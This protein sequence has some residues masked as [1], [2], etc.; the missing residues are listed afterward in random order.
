MFCI[1]PW[2]CLEYVM[3]WSST[4]AS[5]IDLCFYGLKNVSKITNSVVS[6]K[7][8]YAST[9]IFLRNIKSFLLWY[10]FLVNYVH[11]CHSS[12]YSWSDNKWLAIKW[13]FWFL[14]CCQLMIVGLKQNRDSCG[15]VWSLQLRIVQK[16]RKMLLFILALY[17]SWSEQHSLL[18]L[19]HAH[20]WCFFKKSLHL[21]KVISGYCHCPCH[22]SL[23]SCTETSCKRVASQVAVVLTVPKQFQQLAGLRAGVGVNLPKLLLSTALQE[24]HKLLHFP[25]HHY[26]RRNG[27]LVCSQL[28]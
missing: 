22:D 21:S 16:G 25:C 11:P 8:S 7:K 13:I 5:K 19:A 17:R 9:I 28:S 3:V 14:P 2:K 1:F 27:N 4:R 6:M 15:I 24:L 26:C 20:L 10:L 18:L 12:I 23:S